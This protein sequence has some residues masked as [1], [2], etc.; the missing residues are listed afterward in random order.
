MNPMIF[1]SCTG[2]RYPDQTR[3]CSFVFSV[4]CILQQIEIIIAFGYDQFIHPEK[5]KGMFVSVACY[6]LYQFVGLF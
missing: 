4:N 3:S 2:S 5:N 6:F 1:H